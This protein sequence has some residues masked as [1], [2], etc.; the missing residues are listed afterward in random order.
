MSDRLLP[1][2]AHGMLDVY[3]DYSTGKEVFIGRPSR[4]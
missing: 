1:I 2:A 4:E 3:L